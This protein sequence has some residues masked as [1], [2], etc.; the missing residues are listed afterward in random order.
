MTGAR[1]PAPDGDDLPDWLDQITGVAASLGEDGFE[2]N[3][4]ALLNRLLPV[5]HCTVFTFDPDGQAGHLFTSSKMP[6]A[7]AET[8]ARE[9]VSGYYADDPNYQA[10]RQIGAD[11]TEP[12]LALAPLDEADR[13]NRDY[14]Q[15]FFEQ[16][17]LIDKAAAMTRLPEGVVYCS[18]YRMGGS[19]KFSGADRARLARV[20]PLVTSLIGAHYRLRTSAGIKGAS[21]AP[22]PG[23]AQSVVH[24]VI[25]R[26]EP[27][28]DRLTDREREVCA[29]ILL[30]YTSEAIGL[31]LDIAPTSVA[32]YRKRAYARLGIASQNELFGLCL[33]AV[34]RLSA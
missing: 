18:F 11:E 20:L 29:R 5:D 23:G 17:D 30:G 27:P 32:T 22:R 15:R 33:E 19:E 31:D 4:M 25:G 16:S 12:R 34:D 28:F 21:A 13:Y 6:E 9:Y 3:L 10:A 26:A 8:L 7:K 14:R 1:N 2:A 24:S